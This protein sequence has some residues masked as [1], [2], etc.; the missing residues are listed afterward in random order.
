MAI[1]TFLPNVVLAYCLQGTWYDKGKWCGGKLWFLGLMFV[2]AI[3]SFLLR[4][5][6]VY[7]VGW[8][9]IVQDMLQ[10]SPHSV[11]I[12]VVIPPTVDAIQTVVLITA[13]LLTKSEDNNLP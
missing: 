1:I 12:A 10:G 2:A 9:A 8:D 4:L 13:S 3:L 6:I 11:L 5:E 7:K